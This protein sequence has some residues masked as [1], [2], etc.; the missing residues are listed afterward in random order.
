[1]RWLPPAAAVRERY[2]LGNSRD[3]SLTRPPG[4]P[5]RLVQS[6]ARELKSRES[7]VPAAFTSVIRR[8]LSR[9][10]KDD[11]THRGG[12]APSTPHASFPGKA[13]SSSH[14][15]GDARLAEHAGGSQRPQRARSKGGECSE[16]SKAS[17]GPVRWDVFKRASLPVP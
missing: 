12:F 3:R 10:S 11:A 8:D 4:P 17:R 6:I 13:D 1:M 16:D 14:S 9:H 7:S 15:P 2:G 5:A